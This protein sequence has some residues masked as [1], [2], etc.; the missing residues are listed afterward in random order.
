MNRARISI[1]AAVGKNLAIGKDGKLL[2]HISDDLKRFKRLTTG[3]AIIMG[4]KTFKS[5]GRALPDRTNIVI[6]RNKDF[7]TDGALI[8]GSLEEAIEIAE[9]TTPP[10]AP[11]LNRGGD[12]EIFVIGGGEIYAQALSIAD[13][14]YLTLVESNADGDTFFPD[15]RDNFTKETFNEERTDAKT[16][17]RYVWTDVE[18]Y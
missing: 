17:L 9:H 2:W 14:L 4:R 13:K 6:T 10:L 1:I 5:I 16:G 12:K 8:A 7:N 15:W 11:L 18:R 3:H